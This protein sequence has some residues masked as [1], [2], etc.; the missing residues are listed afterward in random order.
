[1]ASAVD[2][3]L[4]SSTVHPPEF[5][6]RR[7][8]HIGRR[9]PRTPLFHP[10]RWAV[11]Q[12][13]VRPLCHG[14]RKET[15]LVEECCSKCTLHRLVVS[16]ESSCPVWV[17]NSLVRYLFATILSVYNKWMFSPGLYGFPA[18]LFVTTLHMFV[19]FLLAASIRALWP[20]HFKPKARPTSSGYL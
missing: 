9:R 7:D 4:K 8:A 1:M 10:R 5:R 11:T 19:Q 3:I 20:H 18:P 6:A 12:Y 16:T 2:G 17:T 15:T 14:G 13:P